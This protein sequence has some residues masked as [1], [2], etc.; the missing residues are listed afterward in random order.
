M[1]EHGASL[2][3]T[4][5]AARGGMVLRGS[6]KPG[7]PA[8]PAVAPAGPAVAPDIGGMANAGALPIPELCSV[9]IVASPHPK[10]F[11]GL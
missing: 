11:R 4:R 9:A 7:R 3:R 1:T 5:A 2:L 10:P 6:H 8:T